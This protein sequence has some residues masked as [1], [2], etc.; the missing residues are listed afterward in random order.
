MGF[1]ISASYALPNQL[2]SNEQN[3]CFVQYLEPSFNFH[4]I[5]DMQLCVTKILK[6]LINHL[7]KSSVVLPKTGIYGMRWI[8]LSWFYVCYNYIYVFLNI[9]YTVTSIYKLMIP[10]HFSSNKTF[11]FTRVCNQK[12]E[13]ISHWLKLA[14]CSYTLYNTMAFDIVLLPEFRNVET[15]AEQLCVKNLLNV[16]QQISDITR[17]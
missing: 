17:I 15:G 3:Y 6:L 14:G 2:N 10:M 12:F 8:P 4:G 9:S 1:E 16:L 13:L 11:D 7:L 5:L